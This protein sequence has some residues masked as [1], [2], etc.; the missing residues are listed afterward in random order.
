M[1][2][3]VVICSHNSR[4][5][6]LGRVLDALR[7]QT[8]PASAWELCLVDNASREP[9]AGRVDL[10][11]LPSAR[12]V[13]N[14]VP[15]LEAGLVD[16]RSLGIRST[17]GEILTFVD[18]DNVLAPDYLAQSVAIARAHP[19][20][21]AWGGN[22]ILCYEQPELALPAE[23]EGILCQ[24][25]LT[26]P[27]WSNLRDHHESTPWG[28]GLC[29]RRAVATAHLATL[30]REP[31]RRQLDPV[32]RSMRFGGD[33]DMVYTGLKLGFGKG[34]FPTLT[35][36]HLIPPRR[37]DLGFAARAIEAGGYSAVLHGWVE[38][39]VAAAPRTDWRYYLGEILRWPR[40]SRWQRLILRERRRGQ[41]RAYHELKDQQP[42]RLPGSTPIPPTP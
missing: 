28:A 5:D 33:T 27:I 30:E 2:V 18:D 25:H 21:G 41:W 10:S 12:I 29:V 17:T 40:R 36:T 19:D 37:C 34:V 20:L 16:A 1:L 35:V 26:A 42:R 31:D 39:G 23:L 24:R 4:L 7:A 32:G 15:E 9:L 38:T 14:D 6:Y 13:R 22:I 11:G 3:S 8:L